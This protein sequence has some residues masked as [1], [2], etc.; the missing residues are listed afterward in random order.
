[1][2]GET[3]EDI[4]DQKEGDNKSPSGKYKWIAVIL[5]VAIAIT[6][7]LAVMNRSQSTEPQVTLQTLDAK[8]DAV[9]ESLAGDVAEVKTDVA[10]VKESIADL[11]SEVDDGNDLLADI[12]TRLN[13]IDAAIASLASEV[14]DITAALAACNCTA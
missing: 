4:L 6:V 12:Q 1:M 11:E 13:V 9:E 10:W 8:I 3:E 2:P 5:V 14:G 7:P